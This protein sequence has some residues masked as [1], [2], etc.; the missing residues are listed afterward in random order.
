MKCLL[1]YTQGD[2]ITVILD[3]ESKTISFAKNGDDPVIAF[4]EV[5]GSPLY[6]CVVFYSTNPGE[7]VI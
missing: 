3:M 4:E 7:K 6:P 1:N 5:D 2:Y